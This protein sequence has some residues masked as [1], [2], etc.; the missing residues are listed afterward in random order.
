MNFGK[1]IEELKTGKKVCRSG[2]NGK[3]QYVSVCE[4]GGFRDGYRTDDFLYLKNAQDK[5]WALEGY[6]LRERLAAGQ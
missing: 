3:G 6:A 5:I 4:G 1:A 2:W